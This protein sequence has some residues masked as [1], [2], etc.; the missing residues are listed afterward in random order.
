[1]YKHQLLCVGRTIE[2]V[3]HGSYVIIYTCLFAKGALEFGNHV[4]YGCSDNITNNIGNQTCV[5][6]ANR[7][8]ADRIGCRGCRLWDE[9]QVAQIHFGVPGNDLSGKFWVNSG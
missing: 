5:C 9:E 7:D 6:I 1:M 2:F 3:V 4:V 8:G